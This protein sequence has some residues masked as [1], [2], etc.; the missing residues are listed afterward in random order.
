MMECPNC[1]AEHDDRSA[2]CPSCG[3]APTTIDGFPAWAPELAH[4]G[5][6]FKAEYFR[7]LAGVEATSFWF[8]ARNRLIVWAL[9]KWF[10]KFRSL[11]EVGCGTG[12]VLRGIAE[13]FP[14]AKL[15]GSEIFTDGLRFASDRVPEADFLQ[16]DA[17]SIPFVEKFDVVA[18]FDVLEHIEEDVQVL[19]ELHRALV[20]G[21]GLLVTVPQHMWLWSQIDEHSCHVRRYTARELQAKVSAAG[22]EILRST[23]FVSFLL[24]AM[25]FSRLA[26][27]RDRDA[28]AE[29]R[30]APSLNAAMEKIMDIEAMLIRR[31]LNF[32]AGGSRL[33]VARKSP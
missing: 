25:A 7:E 11:M 19:A 15:T 10:P 1:H 27:R 22:F 13:A 21:G 5:G 4:G 9:G 28:G 14:R 31:G 32:P 8:Q 26:P 30:L 17:R 16:M 18:A 20:P 33:M 29:M 12:F 24:P 3:F 23:S 2:E 6:G